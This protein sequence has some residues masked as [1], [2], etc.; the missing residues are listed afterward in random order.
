[1]N[2]LVAVASKHGSTREIAAVIA[3]E[4]R[5]LD[6]HTDVREASEVISLAGY[7]AAIIGSAVYAG[8][9]RPEA[10]QLI[11]RHRA[12]L[13]AM[14]I[15]LFSSGPLGEGSDQ[16]GDINGMAGLLAETGAREHVIFTGNL[17]PHDL[18]IA[19]RLVVRVVR[20]PAG[21]FRD[22]AAIRA[23]ARAIGA[24]RWAAQAPGAAA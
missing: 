15:W 6:L 17:D 20:A 3:Q 12:R 19:E 13:A 18:S 1:M 9:W 7:D 5:L 14:P 16:R 24:A 21:D 4:L 11:A 22:W 8:N 23:W 10:R 2:V